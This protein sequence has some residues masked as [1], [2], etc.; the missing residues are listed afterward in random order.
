MQNIIAMFA[1]FIISIL[2]VFGVSTDNLPGWLKDLVKEPE[3][4]D[5]TT[6][7]VA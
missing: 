7:V 5:S 1:R 3:A 2:T 6:S 4:D